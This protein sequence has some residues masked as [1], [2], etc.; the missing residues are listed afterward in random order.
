MEINDLRN[1][2]KLSSHHREQLSG[3]RQCGCFYCLRIFDPKEI[4]DW[5]DNEQT[6]ICPYCH[7][8]SI[9]PDSEACPISKEFLQQMREYWFY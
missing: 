6:A 9:I 4:V 7:I 2:H 3:S 8:D 1:A 5:C